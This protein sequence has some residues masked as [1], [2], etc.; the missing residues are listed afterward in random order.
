[1]LGRV[2]IR[3]LTKEEILAGYG[4]VSKYARGVMR[5]VAK[6][7]ILARY[8]KVSKYAEKV[9]GRVLMRRKAAEEILAGYERTSK[10][11]EKARLIRSRAGQGRREAEVFPRFHTAIKPHLKKTSVNFLLFKSIP[12]YVLIF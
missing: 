5:R 4:K 3:S 2:V 10:Y 1:M 9:L 12:Y 6:E 8:E 11:A 7:N